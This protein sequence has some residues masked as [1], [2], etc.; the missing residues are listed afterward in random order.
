MQ[1]IYK[2]NPKLMPGALSDLRSEM[3]HNQFLGSVSCS[4]GFPKLLNHLSTTLGMTITNW[5]TKFEAKLVESNEL[6][7][8]QE[9]LDGDVLFF[10]NQLETAPK[11][12]G[13]IYESMLGA[14][15]L[16]SGFR[17]EQVAAV[18][19]KTLIAPWWHR[20]KLLIRGSEGLQIKHP[21][22]LLAEHIVV[23]KCI[24]FSMM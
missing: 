20:F 24:E 3:V 16:D 10:W 21:V 17:I 7:E 8:T 14:V 1:H 11:V 6:I 23:L 15:F 19:E 12:L 2:L 9:D 4:L 13:D 5:V 18:V 22:R